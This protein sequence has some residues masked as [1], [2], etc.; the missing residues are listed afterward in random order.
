MKPPIVV[1]LNDVKPVPW[2][3][4][5]GSTQV[6]WNVPSLRVS[7]ASLIS[8]AQFSD[9]TGFY[10]FF[11]LLDGVVDLMIDGQERCLQPLQSVHFAGH[12]PVSC[13]VKQASR[14]VNIMSPSRLSLAAGHYT[15]LPAGTRAVVLDAKGCRPGDLV[16]GPWNQSF[17]G[18][19]LPGLD[20]ANG[21]TGSI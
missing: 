10:R 14:A 15:T 13:R 9:F 16:Q 5:R 18:V 17:F 3:N 6:V 12:V 1:V 2:R 7:V 21:L 11:L 20:E 19:V 8:D 4:G